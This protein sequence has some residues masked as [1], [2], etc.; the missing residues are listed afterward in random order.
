M[1]SATMKADIRSEKDINGKI[2]DSINL[3]ASIT[4]KY[5]QQKKVAVCERQCSNLILIWV[6]NLIRVIFLRF[7]LTP[8]LVLFSAL[9]FTMPFCV[10]IHGVVSNALTSFAL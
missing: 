9:E 1:V 8:F 4:E 3:F 6:L 10:L 2:N 5:L 7:H